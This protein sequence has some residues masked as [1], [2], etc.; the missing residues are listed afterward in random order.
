MSKK[1]LLQ[2]LAT[3]GMP[4]IPYTLEDGRAI[5]MRAFAVK[6]LKL[7]LM[8]A[9][10]DNSQEFQIIQVL[11]Q[12]IDQDIDVNALPSHE[13]EILYLELF[14]L[15]KGSSILPVSY[16]CGN[17][18][19]GHVCGET[20]TVNMNLNSVIKI[21]NTP[22]EIELTEGVKLKLRMP[23][24]KEK[25]YF[26][27][28]KSRDAFN[29]AMNC[30]CEVI[31]PSETMIVGEDLSR[32]ELTEVI[33]YMDVNVFAEIMKWVGSLPRLELNFPVRCPKCRH[34]EVISLEGLDEFF[35]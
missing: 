30:V 24:V 9:A 26:S 10:G 7:L 23:T 28:E 1:Q 12:C 8:A 21:D 11:S 34:E 5:T 29:L 2:S 31:T 16:T 13:V 4:R 25:D 22:R 15:S 18:V 6:E 33:E 20:I 35:E 27:T 17:Q 32:E 3:A 14:K 19:D